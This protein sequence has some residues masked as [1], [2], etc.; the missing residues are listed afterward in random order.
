MKQTLYTDVLV[1][2]RPVDSLASADETKVCS[3]GGRGF[4]Q[5]PRP[6]QWDAHHPPVHE[7]DD[8]LVFGD[9]DLLNTGIAASRSVHT[10]LPG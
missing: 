8:N 6:R 4:G 9:A 10:T 3:L 7:I 1:D 5:P 2:C